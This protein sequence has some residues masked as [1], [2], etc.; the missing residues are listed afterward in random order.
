[1][2]VGGG[3]AAPAPAPRRAGGGLGLRGI[4]ERVTA[5][6]GRLEVRSAPGRGTRLEIE[7]PLEA[8]HADAS[9]DRR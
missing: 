3:F 7:I 5:L 8:M 2:A 1:V 9:A 4:R 6:G